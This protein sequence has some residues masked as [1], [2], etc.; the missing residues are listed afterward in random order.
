[1]VTL[2]GPKDG[3]EARLLGIH[4]NRTFE[5]EYAPDPYVEQLN[6]RPAVPSLYDYQLQQRLD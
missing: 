4:G 5:L 6:Q 3:V 2:S 1:M